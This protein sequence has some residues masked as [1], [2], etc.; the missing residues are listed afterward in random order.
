MVTVTPKRPLPLS[1]WIEATIRLPLGLSAE[2]GPIKLAPYMREIADA[3]GD[4]RVERGT[5][6]KS[7]RIGYTALLT[8]ALAHFIVREPSPTLVLTPTECETDSFVEP[9]ST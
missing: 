1:K 8:S 5:G 6:L 7:A 2:R 3:I 4:P 9:C